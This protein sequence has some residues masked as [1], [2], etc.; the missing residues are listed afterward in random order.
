[1]ITPLERQM[2]VMMTVK[3][4]NQAEIGAQLQIQLRSHIAFLKALVHRHYVSP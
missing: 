2:E 4:F 1:M 3:S